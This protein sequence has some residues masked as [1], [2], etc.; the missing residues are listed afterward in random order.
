MNISAKNAQLF[1][2]LS[3]LTVFIPILGYFLFLDKYAVNIPYLDDYT[4]FDFLPK[5]FSEISFGEKVELFFEQHNEHRIFLNRV[6]AFLIYWL[7]GN[8]DYR[9]MIFI[10]NIFLLG[11]VAI[12]YHYFL[13]L[14]YHLLYFI[15][16]PFLFFQLQFWE[17][18][19]WGMASIQNFGVIFILLIAIHFIL[20][21]KISLFYLSLCF[22][23][24]ATYTSGNG[25]LS[26]FVCGTLLLLQKRIKDFFIFCLWALLLIGTY[27]YHYQSPKYIHYFEGV[28]IIAIGQG[29]LLFIGSAFDLV[30]NMTS[31]II[32]ITLVGAF[33]L[34]LVI[35]FLVKYLIKAWLIN[36]QFEAIELFLLGCFLFVLGTAFIVAVTR[37]SF[38]LIS[39]FVSRYKIYSVLLIVSLYF[40][41]LLKA[42]RYLLAKAIIPLI[43]LSILYNLWSNYRNYYITVHL[44][45]QRICALI[46]NLIVSGDKFDK[47]NSNIYQ[48]PHLWFNEQLGSLK[49]PIIE[50]PKWQHSFYKTPYSEMLVFESADFE[51]RIEGK[52]GVYLMLQSS[53]RV[54][55]YPVSNHSSSMRKFLRTGDFWAK[56]FIG[57]L[58]YQFIDADTYQLGLWI[59]DGKLGKAYNLNDSIKI[60]HNY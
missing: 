45:K 27:F 4:F 21:K 9:V 36:R 34:G 16:V 2:V 59:Q 17:N 58:E 26:I 7:N 31:R 56:G 35:F 50:A 24:L 10:G 49:K 6:F 5:L 51:P 28:D 42:D 60:E 46:N 14:K 20:S 11:I 48:I 13:R 23:F 37:V 8:L 30:S 15:P 3:L 43:F 1:K 44:Q 57:S 54:Y 47:L 41:L 12:F 29:F 18:S 53:K 52:F 32:L 39:L 22:V 33:L 55:I 40:C 19:F 38:G 25:I